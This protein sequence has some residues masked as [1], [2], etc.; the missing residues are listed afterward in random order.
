M[1]NVSILC[2]QN[3]RLFQQK[4]W[5]K[6]V[7][8]H[9]HY[10]IMGYFRVAKFLLFCLKNMAII[11]RRFQFSRSATSAKNYFDFFR[12]NHGGGGITRLSLDRSTMRKENLWPK[13]LKR[14][15][16]KDTF[17]VLPLTGFIFLN[18]FGLLECLV[19]W[20]I[21]MPVIKV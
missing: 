11:F 16:I 13:Y 3:I 19:M 5:Y 9:M 17:P 20:L 18:L 7:L 15:G 8:L 21:S 10:R 12:E 1:F 14:M 6:L 2:K 4:L